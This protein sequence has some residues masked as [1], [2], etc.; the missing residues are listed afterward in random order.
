VKIAQICPYDMARPGGVQ[1]HIRDLA[2]ALGER[3]H[4][5]TIIAPPAPG[6]RP[7]HEAG[8]P[9]RRIGR[10]RRIG[11]AG[12]EFEISAARGA[13]RDALQSLMRGGGFDIV[14]YHT[15]W[16]PI[17]PL[18]ALR[19]S[20]AANV[21]TFHDTPPDTRAG[22]ATRLLFRMLGLW[23]MPRLDGVIAVSMAPT[24]HLPV[25]ARLHI[26]PPCTDLRR[27]R[28]AAAPF[29]RWRDDKVNILFLGRLE[30]RKGAMT[31]LRAY[32]DL[33]RSGLDLRLIIAGDGPEM[34]ALQR[35]ATENDVQDVVFA[36]KFD[37]ADAPRWYA[38]CDI[39]CAPSRHGE[40]FGIVIAEAMTSGKPVV[41]VANAG[42]RALLTGE[43]AELLVPPGDVEALARTLEL[44]ARDR[45]LRCRLGQWGRE[46]AVRYDCRTVVP[47]ILAVY[48]EA[49]AARA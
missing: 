2:G 35:F 40:S 4:E 29:A 6:E 16:T 37:D 44:L 10:S 31:L 42:Y 28:G 9:V 15:I 30:P 47:Y 25:T 34:G 21:A 24:R 12:T 14:H 8:T 13:E 1:A 11:F 38:T 27:F 39:F 45:D 3:G 20:R 19:A 32:R 7:A 22:A 33:V 48:D 18:Q 5:V 17:L 49:L 43:A 46:Q 23:L 36:G 26:V 41:A